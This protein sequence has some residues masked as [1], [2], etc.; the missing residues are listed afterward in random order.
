MVVNG[1]LSIGTIGELQAETL[2]V[3]V[4][5]LEL[6]GR[7]VAVGRS[8]R[9]RCPRRRWHRLRDKGSAGYQLSISP[10]AAPPSASSARAGRRCACARPAT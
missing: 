1:S 6:K 5:E 8:R 2:I 7:L 9:A 10:T 4:D 3:D